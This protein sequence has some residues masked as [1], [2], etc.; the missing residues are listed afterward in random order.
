MIEIPEACIFTDF[1]LE[2]MDRTGRFDWLDTP[3]TRTDQIVAVFVRQNQREVRGTL[4]QAEAAYETVLGEALE[5]PE[6]RR[7]IAL[8]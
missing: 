5:Q 3:T 4:V 2:L 1:I 6:N 8:I 7:L